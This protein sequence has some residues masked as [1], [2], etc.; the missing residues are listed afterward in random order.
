VSW[1]N[2]Q[3]LHELIAT[4]GYWAVGI[5]IGLESMG[6]PLPGETTLVLSA[7]Y[8]HKHLNIW[9]VIGSAATGAFLG[10]NVG[11]W[12]GREFG[13]PLLLRYRR[14]IGLSE[15]KIKLGQYLF[16][17]HGGKVVLRRCFACSALPLR[18]CDLR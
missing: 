8:A 3:N 10:D 12:I 5:I 14:Y 6:L 15:E 1:L 13:Y 9:G 18:S 4:Y 16:L 2:D 7:L 17:R 11:Y